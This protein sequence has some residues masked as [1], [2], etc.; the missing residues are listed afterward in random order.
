[1]NPIQDLIQ[2]LQVLP[3]VGGKGAQRMALQLLQRNRDGAKTLARALDVAVQS[4]RQCDA[5]RTL[6][7]STTC[8]LCTD[9]QRD[10]DLLC[11]VESP[12]DIWAIETAGGFRGHYFVL[13][14]RLSPI[15][16]VG[17]EELQLDLLSQRI[18]ALAPKEVILATNATVEGETTAHY[19]AQ[20]IEPRVES[21]SR[22][23]HGV[24]LGGELEFIDG[25]TIV[26]AL[27]GRRNLNSL[28]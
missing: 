3:G 18:D 22:I 5:C 20:L 8:E 12:A 6:T 28:D 16:G 11:I 14:G 13:H 10:T 21:V 9:S 19:I 25:G 24:P 17:P 4:I 2:A 23:A 1:M 15:D 26:H 7:D 27:Q